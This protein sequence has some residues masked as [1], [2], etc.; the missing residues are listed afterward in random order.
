MS[1]VVTLYTDGGMLGTNPSPHGAVWAWCGL[2]RAGTM[3]RSASGIVEA[4]AFG[5][6]LSNNNIELMAALFALEAMP[7]N[8]AGVLWTD[9]YTTLCRL[10][11]VPKFRGVPDWLRARVHTQR[12]R[13]G[14]IDA[15]LCK[16]HPNKQELAAGR[17]KDGVPVS[18]WNVW[19]DRECARLA[20]DYKAKCATP[21]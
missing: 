1:E 9:S 2:D 13:F 4:A 3:I 18:P 5:K 8:W 21:T 17:S 14:G 20:K 12:V 19:C 11:R 7:A 10:T 16:G 15:M 6:A